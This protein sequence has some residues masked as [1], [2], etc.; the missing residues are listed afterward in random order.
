MSVKFHCKWL[1]IS[2]QYKALL[3]NIRDYNA[4]VCALVSLLIFCCLAVSICNPREIVLQ[5]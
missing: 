1:S 2:L 5:L 4:V 3:L